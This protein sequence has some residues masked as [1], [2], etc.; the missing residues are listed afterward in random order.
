MSPEERELLN[1]CVSLSEDNN[2]ILH[3]IRRSQSIS[4]FVRVV[5]WVII[6]GSA[7]GAYYFFQPFV[8]AVKGGAGEA[9]DN[10]K[11]LGQ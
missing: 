7:I 2:R 3:A 1:K 5:Y 6:I 11:N 10:L 9:I 4:Q 8:D